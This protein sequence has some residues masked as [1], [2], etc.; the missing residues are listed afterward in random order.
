VSTLSNQEL[1]RTIF[2]DGHPKLKSYQRMHSW[3]PS[4][5]RCKMCFAPFGGIGGMVM[6]LRGKGPANR[7]PRYCGACDKFLK[8]FPGGAEV[9]L[10]MMFVDV[11]G[12]VPTAEKLPPAQFSRLIND[13]YAVATKALIDTDGFVVELR[14]DEVVGVYPPGFSGPLHASKA[15]QAAE[16]LLG[17]GMPRGPD[18]IPVSVG[19]GVHTG[20]VFIGTVSGAEGMTQDISIW[21]D[22]ANIA[23]RLASIAQPGEALISDA[24]CKTAELDCENLELRELQLKGKSVPTAVRVLRSSAKDAAGLQ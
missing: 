24:T 9:E 22:N 4:P 3:L 21:G 17:I 18:G 6:R 11:R 5:P 7:N 10:S 14:G 12:S 20:S 16:H 15:I 19:I 2:V 13:L 23:A 1:W 8:A